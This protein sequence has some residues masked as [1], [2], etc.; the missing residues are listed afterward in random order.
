MPL[1]SAVIGYLPAKNTAILCKH[2]VFNYL[3]ISCSGPLDTFEFQAFAVDPLLYLCSS[4][5]ALL[6]LPCSGTALTQTV[7]GR[8]ADQARK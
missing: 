4:S 7:S 1:G 5:A 8:T 6:H 2:L 3:E